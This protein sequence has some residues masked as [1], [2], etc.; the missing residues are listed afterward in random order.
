MVP[1]AAGVDHF[2]TVEELHGPARAGGVAYALQDARVD[3]R[4][5]VAEL[6][7]HA[8]AVGGEET[9]EVALAGEL[10]VQRDRLL[11]VRLCQLQAACLPIAPAAGGGEILGQLAGQRVG[12]VPAAQAQQQAGAPFGDGIVAQAGIVLGHQ[13]QCTRIEALGQAE[14]DL[15]GDGDLLVA[16][17]G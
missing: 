4:R 5:A 10:L 6:V 7:R 17:E 13:R 1:L 2:A 14:T 15:A 9:V 3:V 11:A 16:G 12:F 8:Q